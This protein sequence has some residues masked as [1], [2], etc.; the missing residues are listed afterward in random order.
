MSGGYV[1]G[2]IKSGECFNR[3]ETRETNPRNLRTAILPLGPRSRD[4]FHLRKRKNLPYGAGINGCLRGIVI[5]K[6]SYCC[7]ICVGNQ[8][9]CSRNLCNVNKPSGRKS[10]EIIIYNILIVETDIGL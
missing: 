3:A 6:N 9:M 8:R 1:D 2:L 4:K 7:L 10:S 5:L